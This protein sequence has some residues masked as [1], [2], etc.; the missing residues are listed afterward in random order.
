[1]T[2]TPLYSS[3][4]STKT[5]ERRYHKTDSKNGEVF[6]SSKQLNLTC[7]FTRGRHN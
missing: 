7:Q 3:E 6:F 2:I 1:M 5:R 4:K